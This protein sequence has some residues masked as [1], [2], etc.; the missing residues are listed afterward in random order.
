MNIKL[1]VISAILA[2]FGA[3]LSYAAP[4]KLE[5]LAG[6]PDCRLLH[7]GVELVL[8]KERARNRMQAMG[9][10]KCPAV[11]PEDESVGIWTMRNIQIDQN[12]R[13]ARAFSQPIKKENNVVIKVVVRRSDGSL[14]RGGRYRFFFTRLK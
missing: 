6:R 9:V 14:A 11:L 10:G 4:F 12:G 7:D 13:L 2:V 8:R 1:L 5:V 3:N